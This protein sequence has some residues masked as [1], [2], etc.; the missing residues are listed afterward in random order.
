MLAPS[1]GLDFSK[2]NLSYTP[3]QILEGVMMCVDEPWHD[4]MVLQADDL[5]GL[6]M[7]LWKVCCQANPR[8]AVAI[9]VY[10]CISQFSAVLIKREKSAYV[11]NVDRQ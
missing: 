3:R 7:L 2:V 9:D 6:L 5:V 4:Y 10:G 1:S 8:D 11:L